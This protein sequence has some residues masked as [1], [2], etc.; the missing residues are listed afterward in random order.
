MTQLLISTSWRHT[1][2]NQQS[3]RLIVFDLELKQIIRSCEIIEPP[4]REYD[5]NPRGGFRGLKGI[6]VQRDLIAVANASTVFLYNNLWEPV[7]YIW[8]P[9]CAGIHDI[10]LQDDLVWVTSSR[11]DLVCCFD[12][13]GSMIAHI[14]VRGLPVVK[15]L[16]NNQIKPF[17]SRKQ[18]DSGE[19]N[20]RD[21]RTH[22]HAITD[23]LH[24]NSL[25]ILDKGELMVSCGLL[26]VID[27]RF[28]H[29][30]NNW[31]KQ[32]CL[33]K[34]YSSIYQYH[35]ELLKKNIADRFE[36]IAISKQESSSMILLLNG[37]FTV[38]N[39]FRINN[40]NVPSHSLRALD[41]NHVIYLNSSSGDLINFNPVKFNIHSKFKI[42]EKFL[43]GARLIDNQRIVIGDNNH[44]LVFNI[45]E[46]KVISRTLITEDHAEAIFDINILPDHFSLPPESFVEHHSKYLPVD[47]ENYRR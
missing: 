7:N 39:I 47:Q 8:H 14:D 25:F 23:A 40:C 29:K 2:H 30:F 41:Q 24:V 33:S 12:L 1:S 5:P 16:S 21:P 34:L 27:S 46:N 32:T 37:D 36:S 9:S 31:M 28:L 11:N 15:K 3:G 44:L 18:I 43:R 20:F 38:K 35:R 45:L 19:I 4:F 22:D 17:L 6:S 26:R 13:N 42:G 10:C